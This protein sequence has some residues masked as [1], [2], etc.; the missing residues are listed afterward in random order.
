M[1]C[2]LEGST[3]YSNQTEP[4]WLRCHPNCL[5]LTEPLLMSQ[6][7]E[8]LLWSEVLVIRGSLGPCLI[9]YVRL[10]KLYV[11]NYGKA[12]FYCH[13]KSTKKLFSMESLL[14]LCTMHNKDIR[15]WK[16]TP[17][18][19]EIFLL[20]FFTTL[21]YCRSTVWCTC[22]VLTAGSSCS[23]CDIFFF[24]YTRST[25]NSINHLVEPLTFQVAPVLPIM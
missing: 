14:S 16:P 11:L 7:I 15:L 10:D 1:S 25:L 18:V 21:N 2:S 20:S 4:V 13:V 8:V 5:P 17:G 3:V 19:A 12:G 9:L 24:H 6:N 23:S 22:D